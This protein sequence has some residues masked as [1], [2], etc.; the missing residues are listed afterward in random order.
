MVFGAAGEFFARANMG[1]FKP[2]SAKKTD[3]QLTE[4]VSAGG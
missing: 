3:E 1:S 2:N 4:S